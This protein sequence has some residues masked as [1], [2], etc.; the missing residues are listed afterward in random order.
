MSVNLQ[1]GQKVDLTKGNSSLKNLI[2]GLGWNNNKE[3]NSQKKGFFASVFSSDNYDF[4]CDSSVF[5]CDTNGKIANN[6]D[7]I[8]FGRLKHSTGCVQH[9]GDNLTGS[10]SNNTKDDEQIHIKLLE[11]PQNYSKLVFVANIY[12]AIKRKQDFGMISSAFIRIVD[13]DTNKE[14]CRYNLTESYAGK[15]AMIFG[16]VYRHNNEWKFQAIGEGTSDESVSDMA[17][18]YK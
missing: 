14:L 11:V 9:M 2:I 6:E 18:R 4:D 1:K 15:I 17:K 12:N 5:L 7:I 16:E 3:T 8:Y 10:D 13:G